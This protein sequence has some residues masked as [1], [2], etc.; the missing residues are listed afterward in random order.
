MGPPQGFKRVAVDEPNSDQNILLSQYPSQ[1][2]RE[3]KGDL[4][5]NYAAASAEPYPTHTDTEYSAGTYNPTIHTVPYQKRLTERLEEYEHRLFGT[6][7]FSIFYNNFV[8]GWH[9]GLIRSFVLS[10]CAFILNII[11]YAWLYMTYDSRAGTATIMN[12]S[13]T[14]VRNANIGVHAGLNVL[15][16]MVLGA[17]TYAMQGVTAP[18]RQEVDK[19]HAKGTWL[20]IG[21]HSVR[22]LFHVKKRN[23]W[24]WVLL[25]LT[26]VPFHLM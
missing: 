18:T 19:A 23:L 1:T 11:I 22:N 8:S 7:F 20:Q 6:R 24:I 26:S 3:T 25:A 13:C 10:L 21:T 4:K 5:G 15:S 9:A 2:R 14:M 16:T 12:G 17:S